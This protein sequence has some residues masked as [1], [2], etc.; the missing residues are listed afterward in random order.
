MRRE[1]P[2][3]LA[4]HALTMPRCM[5]GSHIGEMLPIL[6]FVLLGGS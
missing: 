5:C 2:L 4:L 6:C 1:S 3:P